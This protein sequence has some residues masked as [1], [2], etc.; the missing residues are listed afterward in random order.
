MVFLWRFLW[1]LILQRS[2][3]YHCLICFSLLV[4]FL[5]YEGF[6][7]LQMFVACS[8]AR[9]HHYFVTVFI[10]SYTM[11]GEKAWEGKG[12]KKS[13]VSSL[14]SRGGFTS[15]VAFQDF[16]NVVFPEETKS[17]CSMGMSSGEVKERRLV[18][19]A[20]TW[21]PALPFSSDRVTLVQKMALLEQCSPL[22]R[23]QGWA[24]ARGRAARWFLFP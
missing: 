9:S 24:E 12:K 18:T 5:F 22:W 13:K 19:M 21:D 16:R 1:Y 7:F 20:V 14:G 8:Y 3:F 4:V 23:S 10:L 11:I 2:N 15:W 17:P 6:L